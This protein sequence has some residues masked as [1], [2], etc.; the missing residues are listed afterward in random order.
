MTSEVI[1]QGDLRT[2][3]TH[4]QSGNSIETDAPTDNKGKGERFSPTDLV[5]T[6]L[7][8]CML[9]IMGIA[10]RNHGFNIDGTKCAVEKIMVP[11]P[12][13]IGE[14]KIDMKFPADQSY[15][16]KTKTIIERAALTCPVFESLHPDC[17]KTINFLWP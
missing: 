8:S 17:K 15:D 7:A 1:Y 10:A 13:R 3:A 11:D 9:T 14:I 4:L 12:R 6:A 5:A 2:S 16:D